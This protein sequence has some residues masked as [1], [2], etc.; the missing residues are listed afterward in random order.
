MLK[1]KSIAPDYLWKLNTAI[2][3]W[4]SIGCSSSIKKQNEKETEPTHDTGDS[5]SDSATD[6]TSRTATSNET[7]TDMIDHSNINPLQPTADC[8]HPEV[9]ADCKDG[10]CRIPGGCFI[11]GSADSEGNLCRGKYSEDQAQVTLTHDFEI[12]QTE[13]TQAQWQAAGFDLPNPISKTSCADCPISWI[14]IYE[15]MAYCNALSVKTGLSECYDL[16]NCTGA[17]AAGCPD[18][19][20]YIWNCLLDDNYVCLG[21]VHQYDNQ[22]ACPGYRLPTTVEW[23]YAARAGT[24]TATYA[25]NLEED[26]PNECISHPSVDTI[27]WH[28][29]NTR[30]GPKSQPRYFPVG[31]KIPNGFGLY[32]MLG[33]VGEYCSSTYQNRS[34]NYLVGQEGALIDPDPPLE[35]Y[36][37]SMFVVLRSSYYIKNAC[38]MRSSYGYPG[39]FAKDRSI[40]QGFRPVRTLDIAPS[41]L[42]TPPVAAPKKKK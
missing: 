34:V 31:K 40:L 38:Y 21:E 25:G 7:E 33:N 32:D 19:E 5:R 12:S 22:Y 17:L 3:L 35:E 15:A 26:I 9:I 23:E 18:D 29:G 4:L 30:D 37:P 41:K 11:F 2:I 42:D 10:W 1:Q 24:R 27:A 16:S 13:T 36:D 28:C 39:A 20:S 14:T 8:I 6:S